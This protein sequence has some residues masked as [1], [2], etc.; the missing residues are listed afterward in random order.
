MAPNDM[1]AMG[2]RVSYSGH[3]GPGSGMSLGLQYGHRSQ[4]SLWP[5]VAMGAMDIN[6]ETGCSRT[7][8]PDMVLGSILGPDVTMDLG[9]YT[10]HSDQRRVALG[11]QHDPR[12]G[13]RPRASIQLS[14]VTGAMDINTDQGCSRAMDLKMAFSWSSSLDVSMAPGSGSGYSDQ[15]GPCGDMVHRTNMASCGGSDHGHPHCL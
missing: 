3:H 1:M 4:A 8:N 9:G 10:G 15:D 14:M 13:P 12:W 5:L 11:H 6:T 7:T 2:G